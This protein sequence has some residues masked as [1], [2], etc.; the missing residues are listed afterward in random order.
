[1]NAFFIL[2]THVKLIIVIDTFAFINF[3][4]ETRTPNNTFKT[5]SKKLGD[6]D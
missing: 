6:F 1:M 3:K 4:N 2:S 5:S